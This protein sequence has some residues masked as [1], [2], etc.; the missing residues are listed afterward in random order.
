MNQR[1]QQLDLKLLTFVKK[2]NYTLPLILL[3]VSWLMPK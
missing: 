2:G 1:Y 3:S